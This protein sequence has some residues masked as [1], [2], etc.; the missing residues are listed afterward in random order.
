MTTL[1]GSTI[2]LCFSLAAVAAPRAGLAGGIG[3]VDQSDK[4]LVASSIWILGHQSQGDTRD[5]TQISIFG[6]GAFRYFVA[7]GFAVGVAGSAYYK[8]AG[9]DANDNGFIVRVDA[10]Y[11]LSLSD[12]LYVAPGLGLGAT[13]G[14]RTT[15]LGNN[16]NRKDDILG[17]TTTLSLP[18]VLYTPGPFNVRA[19]PTLIA[20]FGTASSPDGDESF[21][22]VD[23]GFEIGLGFG[24]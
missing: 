20:T 9:N 8:T 21:T 15:P 23:G 24:F 16:V 5:A 2:I 3:D 17:F 11:Y 12:Q 19:G 1:R 6:T 7:D 4:E 10:S 14:S 22:T 18:L 13:F